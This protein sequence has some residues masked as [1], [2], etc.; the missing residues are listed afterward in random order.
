MRSDLFEQLAWKKEYEIPEK[1]QPHH[2][3]FVYVYRQGTVIG[4]GRWVDLCDVHWLPEGFLENIEN[5]TPNAV[6]EAFREK[7]YAV[8][9]AEREDAHQQQL[10][11]YV[12][13]MSSY[14]CRVYDLLCGPD[15]LGIEQTDL[16]ETLFMLAKAMAGRKGHLDSNHKCLPTIG[17]LFYEY[18]L[19][20]QGDIKALPGC[21]Q[22]DFHGIQNLFGGSYGYHDK[23]GF[24]Y[25]MEQFWKDLEHYDPTDH[26]A[27]AQ[28]LINK[29]MEH[30]ADR[31]D[32]V[33]IAPTLVQLAQ[34][35]QPDG[36]EEQKET[37]LQT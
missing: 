27:L 37:P 14:Y 3:A 28:L 1:P 26:P 6:L 33:E 2:S 22:D 10:D 20:M 13:E 4:S 8:E 29:I 17:K 18:C 7:G 30:N 5:P 31:E 35:D 23:R 34:R 19:A 12:L 36:K 16:T 15:L 25:G 32:P 24:E 9:V 11:Q 21:Y